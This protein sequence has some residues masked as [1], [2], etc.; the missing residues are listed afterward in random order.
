[1]PAF[2]VATFFFSKKECPLGGSTELKVDIITSFCCL[3]LRNQTSTVN[4]GLE[5][6]RSRRES[7][8]LPP[9][10]Q[11]GGC[12]GQVTSLGLAVGGS[13]VHRVHGDGL[14]SKKAKT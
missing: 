6:A 1:M 4:S 7:S 2:L 9:A 3:P 13:G 8:G 11:C 12:E 5:A 10:L 14:V